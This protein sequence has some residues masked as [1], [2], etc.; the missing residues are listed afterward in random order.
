MKPKQNNGAADDVS[1]A[2]Q[3]VEQRPDEAAFWKNKY[4]RLYADLDNTKKRLARSSAQEVE[5]QKE[6]LL[7]EVLPVADGLDLALMHTP[8]KGDN[9][10][11]LQGIE[12]VRDILN[13][14]F[15]I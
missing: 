13:K 15:A 8:D 14:F 11:I 5:E 9:R 6:A 2:S 7:R 4:A 1:R 12:L 10:G 3:P